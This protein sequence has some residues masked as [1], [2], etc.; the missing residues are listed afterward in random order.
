MKHKHAELIKAWAD[1]AQIEFLTTDTG[2]WCDLTNPR[3]SEGVQYRV[4]PEPKPDVVRQL[5]VDIDERIFE[6]TRSNLRLT[7]DG[8]TGK[9]KSAEVA[10]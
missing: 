2:E 5:Y 3:W 10:K 6:S 1:G 9:L 8:E 4:K 7:F